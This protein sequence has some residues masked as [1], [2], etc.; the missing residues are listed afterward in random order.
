MNLRK[1]HTHFHWMSV[2]GSR[3]RCGPWMTPNW[4]TNLL[5]GSDQPHTGSAHV[6]HPGHKGDCG[7]LLTKLPEGGAD[8]KVQSIHSSTK[9]QLPS[10]SPRWPLSLRAGNSKAMG[11]EKWHLL[12]LMLEHASR[13]SPQGRGTETQAKHKRS[14]CR[15]WVDDSNWINNSMRALP[16]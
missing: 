2:R 4:R 12:H 13:L 16:V 5:R 10:W 15:V 3:V 8:F 14:G 6:L 9:L 7:N 11:L 1:K